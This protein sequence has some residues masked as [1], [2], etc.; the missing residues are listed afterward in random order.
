MLSYWTCVAQQML[1]SDFTHHH[2]EMAC[3]LLET[4]GRFLFRSPDSHLRTSVLLVSTTPPHSQLSQSR[5]QKYR[6]K[7][8]NTGKQQWELFL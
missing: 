4:C 7:W 2:I 5:G 6:N 1:L 3:T 8:K